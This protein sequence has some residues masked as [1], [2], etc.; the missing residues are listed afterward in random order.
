MLAFPRRHIIQLLLAVLPLSLSSCVVVPKPLDSAANGERLRE[1]LR[2]SYLRQEKV[3]RPL[4]PE[5]AMARAISYNLDSRVK[6]MQEALAHGEL[7]LARWDMLPKLAANAG[8]SHRS[9]VSASN[10]VNV[11]TGIE[12]LSMSTSQ[13]QDIRTADLSIAWNVLDFGVS[14]FQARQQANRELIW[15]E[16]RRKAI[17]NLMQEVRLAYWQAAGAARLRERATRVLL[18]S[19]EELGRIRVQREA[20]LTS[21]IESLRQEKALLE[22]MRQMQAILDE[23]AVAKPRLASLMGLPPGMAYELATVEL[24]DE[25]LPGMDIP[26]GELERI[27]LEHRPELREAAYEERISADEARKAIARLLPGIELTGSKEYSSNSFAKY[28]NWWE[29]GMAV[30]WNIMSLPSAPQRMKTARAGRE[31]ARESSLA[32]SMA[33]LSQVYVSRRQQAAAVRQYSLARQQWDVDEQMLWYVQAGH[34]L[35]ALS[36]REF[37][38]AEANAVKAELGL[39]MAHASMERAQGNVYASLGLDPFV[40]IDARMPL[41][42]LADTIARA[43]KAWQAGK[44]D[45]IDEETGRIEQS[46]ALYLEGQELFRREEYLRADSLFAALKEI[47]PFNESARQYAEVLI[48]ARVKRIATA[49]SLRLKAREAEK[50]QREGRAEEAKALWNEIIT[51]SKEELNK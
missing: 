17:H 7:G 36:D 41:D 42:K 14:Y 4:S 29:G 2:Q 27:A 12:S 22:A 45:W 9:K 18:A 35:K 25:G 49:Q 51:E 20:R 28:P 10:S 30:S 16:H 1:G 6:L 40:D 44:F 47:D 23:F 34:S 3:R 32:V 50:L 38:L 48:P 33:V 43:T 15:R 24:P 37:I 26:V 8:Y 39:Y 5:D 19:E 46:R 13:D 21:P 11:D 31:L